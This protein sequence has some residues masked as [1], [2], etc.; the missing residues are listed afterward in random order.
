ML[1]LAGSSELNIDFWKQVLPVEDRDASQILVIPS[2]GLVIPVNTVSPDNWMYKSF[3]NGNNE[4]FYKY[5]IDGSV[6]L[7][8][9]KN[10]KYGEVGNKVIAG[11]SSYWKQ[12]RSKY[13]THFQTVIGLEENKEIWMYVKNSSGKY[14]RYVYNVSE[15]YETS[16]DDVSV[17]N[18]SSESEI[19]L[20]TCTP[21]GGIQGRWV[22]K[23]KF[24]HKN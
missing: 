11:H 23:A 13:K 4:N 10:I 24:S 18:H 1:R 8:G 20:I 9:S 12:S 16:A 6:E 17:L 14:D 3:I 19:T 22:V 5:L 2:E 7:P 15:S 21:I